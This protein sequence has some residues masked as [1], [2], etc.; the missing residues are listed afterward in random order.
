MYLAVQRSFTHVKAIISE[1]DDWVWLFVKE[2][3][4]RNILEPK[5]MILLSH[6]EYEV[7]WNKYCDEI[8]ARNN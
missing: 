4:S 7:K 5:D 2:A 6:E 3:E 8:F 1:I